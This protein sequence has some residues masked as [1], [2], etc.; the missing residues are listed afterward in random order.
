MTNRPTWCEYPATEV[1]SSDF[2]DKKH[3]QG[4][5]AQCYGL[6]PSIDEQQVKQVLHKNGMCHCVNGDRWLACQSDLIID[7]AVRTSVLLRLME[8][9]DDCRRGLYHDKDTQAVK[10]MDAMDVR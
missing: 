8:V 9:D 6:L 7:I 4:Y 3:A 1:L 10:G 5:S 2:T